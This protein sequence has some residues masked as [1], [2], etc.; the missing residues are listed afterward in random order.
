MKRILRV[1]TQN[2]NIEKPATVNFEEND[3]SDGSQIKD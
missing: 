3:M 2:Y 1:H